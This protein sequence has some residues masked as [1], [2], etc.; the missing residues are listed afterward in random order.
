MALAAS[1]CGRGISLAGWGRYENDW[2]SEVAEL[3][4]KADITAGSLKVAESRVIADLLLRDSDRAMW[5]EAIGAENRLQTRSP[6]TAT[7]LVSLIRP[8]LE[9]MTPDLWALVR[10]GNQ[11]E[12]TH[13][14]LA[15][16]VK[17][18]R[19]LADFF[20]LVLREQYQVFAERLTRQDW[21]V[22]VSD[23]QARDLQM[24]PWSDLTVARVRSSVFQILA[25]AGYVE[26]TKNLRLQ[27]V[28]VADSVVKYLKN[29]EEDG[30]LRCIQISA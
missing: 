22:F 6:V 11:Q 19:L 2:V 28:F 18:S 4:Y 8:R 9:T 7:R 3:R 29:H 30:V 12:A 15:A 5:K 1:P 26:S 17:R 23:C 25:Q 16:A 10:D 13:A 27:T 24:K 21:D 14:C 20:E